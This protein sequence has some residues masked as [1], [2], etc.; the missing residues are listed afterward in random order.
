ML[1]YQREINTLSKTSSLLPIVS[2]VRVLVS[3]DFLG[4]CAFWLWR[5]KKHWRT[6]YARELP[7]QGHVS[8]HGRKGFLIVLWG[9]SLAP[10]TWTWLCRIWS[11]NWKSRVGLH[12]YLLKVSKQAHRSSPPRSSTGFNNVPVFEGRIQWSECEAVRAAT[13]QSEVP[14]RPKF[15]RG[16][17]QW[18]IT[19]S[20][21][22]K[23][24]T[25]QFSPPVIL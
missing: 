22:Q 12:T 7:L 21:R 15:F 14:K 18:V 11:W 20:Q 5:P 4:L 10:N 16:N 19:K 17:T 8:A 13:W 3:G 9:L 6:T 23:K 25:Y 1:C 2:C 24:T